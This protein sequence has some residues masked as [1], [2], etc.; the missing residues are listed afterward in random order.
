MVKVILMT[1]REIPDHLI[2]DYLIYISKSFLPWLNVREV[3]N[4]GF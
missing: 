2:N 1:E 4:K 3:L